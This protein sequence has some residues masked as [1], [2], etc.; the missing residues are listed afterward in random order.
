VT[1]SLSIVE[2]LDH[3]L[4]FLTTE[5][6]P[7]SLDLGIT[8]AIRQFV[9]NWS[10]TLGIASEFSSDGVDG[11]RLQPGIETHLYR[12][13]QEALNNVAKHADASCVNVSVD[14]KGSTL[15]VTVQD[16]GCG[17][18]ADAQADRKAGVGLIGM[19]E[20][21][22]IVRGSIEVLTAPGEGTTIRLRVPVESA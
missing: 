1:Q 9:D 7:A 3:D 2:Q 19:R 12:V 4:D 17:F 15:V 16:D 18:R 14:R 11:L 10:A 22:Q 21:T 6:R 5:L 13:V 8:A 20:R